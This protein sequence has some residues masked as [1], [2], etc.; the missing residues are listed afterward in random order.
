M[1][2]EWMGNEYRMNDGWQDTSLQFRRR[3]RLFNLEDYG[4]VWMKGR[5]IAS[6]LNGWAF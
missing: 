2:D 5:I 6:L 4:M 1:A 3:F